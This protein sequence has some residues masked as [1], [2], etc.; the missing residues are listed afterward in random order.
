MPIPVKIFRRHPDAE[1]PAYQTIGACAFDLAVVEDAVIPPGGQ[2]RLR[3]G[4]V[5]CVPEGHALVVAPR[6][7]LFRKKGLIVPHSI[8]IVD[9]DFCGPDDE[10]LLGL[11][12]A[13][14]ADVVVR[15]GERLCQGMILPISRAAFEEVTALDAPSRGGWGSTG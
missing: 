13:T 9:M 1:I 12:N 8:G 5:V 15:K 7:S 2:V 10:I 11:Q 14:D 3:T 4:L 6:S